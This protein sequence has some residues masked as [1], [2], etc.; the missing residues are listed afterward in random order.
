MTFTEL[1]KSLAIEKYPEKFEEIYNELPAD[2]GALYDVDYLKGLHEKYNMFGNYLELVLR[3]VEDLKTKP[4]LILWG[5]I[6]VE[7]NRRVTMHEA[8]MATFPAPDGSPARDMLPLLVMM[9]IV[10]DMEKRYADRGF[11]DAQI[12]KNMENFRINLWVLELLTGTPKFTAGMYNWLCNYTYAY[13]FDHK[14]FNYQPHIWNTQAIILK[15]LASGESYPMMLAGSFHRDGLALGSAGCEDDEGS[16]TVTYAETPDIFY[17][18]LVNGGRVEK[19]PTVC[20][21]SEWKCIVRPG[22]DVVSLHIP[23]NTNLD[24]AYVSESF[25]EGMELTR[26]FY[27]E[28][29]PKFLACSSW[30]MDSTLSKILGPEAKLSNFTDRFIKYPQ[31]SGGNECLGY[32]YPGFKGEVKDYPEDTRLRREIKKLMLNN[33]YI[34]WTNAIIPE[35]M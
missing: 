23:R 3:G 19:K 22:D 4:E 34:H 1:A 12:Y 13:I 5:R 14:G 8:K 29:S 24:P 20:K 33:T 27:P 17:G 11:S 16:F 35:E 21:K 32:V 9:P 7:Y 6:I 28:L 30:L 10:P 31:K 15:N 25:K 18:H 26:R 2:D